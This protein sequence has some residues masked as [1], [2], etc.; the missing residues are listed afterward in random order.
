M[1]SVIKIQMGQLSILG[2]LIVI[3]ETRRNNEILV[4][5]ITNKYMD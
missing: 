3:G 5:D 1:I 4:S 2:R